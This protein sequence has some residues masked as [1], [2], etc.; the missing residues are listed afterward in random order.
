MEKVQRLDF[1]KLNFGEFTDELIV[2][3]T[4]TYKTP[5]P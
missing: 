4:G 5:N 2:K 3:F 1:R